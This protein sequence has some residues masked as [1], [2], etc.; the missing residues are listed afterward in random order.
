MSELTNLTG[1]NGGGETVCS[2]HIIVPREFQRPSEQHAPACSESEHGKTGK[3]DKP[4][5]D[6]KLLRNIDIIPARSCIPVR[7]I[8]NSR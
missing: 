1:G 4:D 8:L 6:A 5:W 3:Q 2:V 7:V